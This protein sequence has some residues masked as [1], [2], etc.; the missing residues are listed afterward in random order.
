MGGL[1]Q[2]E[3]YLKRTRNIPWEIVTVVDDE[4]PGIVVPYHF[5]QIIR[6]LL[7]PF[8]VYDDVNVSTGKM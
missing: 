4:E 2:H 1:L 3:A 7:R 8:R 5:E 6:L